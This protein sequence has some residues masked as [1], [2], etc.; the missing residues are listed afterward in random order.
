RKSSEKDQQ[1]GQSAN[2]AP[3]VSLLQKPVGPGGDAYV[4]SIIDT[5]DTTVSVT[6]PPGAFPTTTLV[7]YIPIMTGD[8]PSQYDVPP[9]YV[10]IAAGIGI[11]SGIT[12]VSSPVTITIH[13]SD[14]RL[15]DPAYGAMD[16]TTLTA[17]KFDAVNNVWVPISGATVDTVAN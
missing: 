17:F 13:Y 8:V 2:T 7:S 11:I 1:A 3:L 12:S 9:P 14:Y 15:A 16:E 6:I 5:G 10:R 4:A